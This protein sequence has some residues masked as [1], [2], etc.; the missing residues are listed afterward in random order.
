MTYALIVK[1]QNSRIEQVETARFGGKEESSIL[2]QIERVN[3]KR[4]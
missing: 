2:F 1:M 3:I 4:I